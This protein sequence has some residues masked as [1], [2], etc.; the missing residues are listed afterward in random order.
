MSAEIS[1]R[2]TEERARI[3]FSQADM[4]RKIGVSRETM[5]KW[6]AG[7]ATVSSEA[8]AVAFSLGVDVQYVL[9]GLRAERPRPEE[10]AANTATTRSVSGGVGVIQG[11]E[12]L[13]IQTPRYVTR[14]RPII[15]RSS[16]KISDAQAAVLHKLVQEVVDTEAKLKAK[17]KGHR[18]VWAAL[19]AHCDVTQ[20]RLIPA[21]RFE[22][23]RG[24]LNAWI[25]RLHSMASAPAKD[26]DS[27]R[28]RH[29]AYIKINSREP[30]VKADL[31]SYLYR[32]FQTTSLSDLANDQL[33][34][35]YRYIAG[36]RRKVRKV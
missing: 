22:K 34:A 33:E 14:V 10:M 5:R 25:G 13:I 24:Y 35:A 11:N 7:L 8:L 36:R 30:D 1:L 29:Y 9:T 21:E 18:A 32:K 28:K 19:N 27:W 4:A 2:L 17:P 20:Y 16:G 15:D 6:E 3:G 12:N 26:G 23:A 31:D